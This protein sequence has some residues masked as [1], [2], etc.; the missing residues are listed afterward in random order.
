MVVDWH[1]T[2]LFCVALGIMLMSCL[3][4]LFTL[5]ILALGGEELN[6]VMKVLLEMDTGTFLIAKYCATALG[7]IFLVALSRFRMAGIL[8]VRRLL[9]AIC[10]GYAC[11]IIYE[12]YLLLVVASDVHFLA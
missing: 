6:L 3:D 8:P 4:A 1:D 9:E 2:A 5:N 11:L 10:V 12:L 7:V